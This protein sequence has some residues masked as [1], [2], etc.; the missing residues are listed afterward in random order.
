MD[1]PPVSIDSDELPNH[2]FAVFL[3]VPHSPRIPIIESFLRQT[4]T[5]EAFQSFRYAYV[6]YRLTNSTDSKYL[7]VPPFWFDIVRSQRPRLDDKSVSLVAMDFFSLSYFLEKRREPWFFR[8]IDDTVIN[9]RRVRSFLNGLNAE[10]DGRRDVIV[11]GN[12]VVFQGI[13]YIQ[14]GS[15]FVCSRAA[16]RLLNNVT[17]FLAQWRIAED[18]TM[19]PFLDSL[20][21]GARNCCSGA[22]MGHGSGRHSELPSVKQCPGHDWA[23]A[24]LPRIVEP[25]RDLLSYHRPNQIGAGLGETVRRASALFNA[26]ES[27]RW[28]MSGDERAPQTCMAH[29]PLSWSLGFRDAMRRLTLHRR[30]RSR[31]NERGKRKT[32]R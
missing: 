28:F 11:R 17:R 21:I 6:N 13:I 10:F 2:V 9:L 7:A 27:V 12:C 24:P 23:R 15:G 26:P 16:A 30:I 19:G 14:G 18:T 4:M 1:D 25:V 32:R 31:V 3:T 8:A 5:P 22:F 20:G 29:A